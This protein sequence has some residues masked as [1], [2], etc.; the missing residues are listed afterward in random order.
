M[1]RG[2]CSEAST[3]VGDGERMDSNLGAKFRARWNLFLDRTWNSF[4]KQ[5]WTELCWA[6]FMFG[7]NSFQLLT[8]FWCAWRFQSREFASTAS[9]S[10][11]KRMSSQTAWQ[12]SGWKG[13]HKPCDFLLRQGV[14][15]CSIPARETQKLERRPCSILCKANVP[16]IPRKSGWSA[17][18]PEIS[19]HLSSGN[20][21]VIVWAGLLSD[22][23]NPTTETEIKVLPSGKDKT[24]FLNCRRQYW[25]AQLEDE[26]D[27]FW[28]AG[29]QLANSSFQQ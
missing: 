10:S 27:P 22:W 8:A 7:L 16:K 18:Q 25:N 23:T 11:C 26:G 3:V 5:S 20:H 1:L 29:A 24:P 15:H 28:F 14:L 6:K 17:M 13:L 9:T 19:T 21:W 2:A 4:S 12:G